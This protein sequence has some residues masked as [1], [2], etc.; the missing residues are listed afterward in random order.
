MRKIS[1]EGQ[2]VAAE[3]KRLSKAESP[4]HDASAVEPEMN[5]RNSSGAVV[6]NR[7]NSTE[8][9]MVASRRNSADQSSAK[10]DEVVKTQINSVA[11]EGAA[12]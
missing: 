2:A 5:R 10:A 8:P 4:K 12:R 1:M 7:K 11:K 3:S 6:A 9:A